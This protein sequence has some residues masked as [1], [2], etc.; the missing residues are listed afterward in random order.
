[1]NKD[2]QNL[3]HTALSLR[4]VSMRFD[5]TTALDKVSVSVSSGSLFGII[6]A[7]GAGK[8][9]MMRIITTLLS[10]LEGDVRV[11]GSDTKTN[12]R[13]IRS[14]IGYMPQRFSLYGDLTVM[15]NLLFFADIF[16]VKGD[17]RSR[18]I[19]RL[20]EFSR[21]TPFQKRRANQLS[22]GMKQKLALSCAL[23]HTP[24]LLLLDEPTTGVDP[25]SRNEFWAILHELQDQGITI[26]V[27]TPYM[28][29]ADRCDE[30]AFIREG[31]IVA[32]GTPA[33]LGKGFDFALYEISRAHEPVSIPPNDQ[34]PETITM[35]Y[36]VGGALHVCT[37]QKNLSP[38]QVLES[39]QESVP[40][41]TMV[42]AIAPAMEDL[43]FFYNQEQ[44]A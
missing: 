31:A 5:T 23:V 19:E 28:D 30:V 27:S 42:Q 16:N 44:I 25:V 29:E 39:I 10:P 37:R 3:D 41:A 32:T 33:Q 13:E 40:E 9:T 43:F 8:T 12:M 17:E 14:A 24:R 34:L 18:R 35:A 1:M 38:Q 36:P 7:D 26:I 4:N 2:S 22:G 6:G 15:E 11:L 21:L 20:L